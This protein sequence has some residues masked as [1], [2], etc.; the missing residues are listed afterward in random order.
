MIELLPIAGLRL[1][2]TVADRIVCLR[3]LDVS[4]PESVDW[5]H[6]QKFRTASIDPRIS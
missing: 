4:F 5:R 6:P 3:Y 1:A 2:P